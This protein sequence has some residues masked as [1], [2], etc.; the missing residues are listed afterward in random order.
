MPGKRDQPDGLGDWREVRRFSADPHAIGVKPGH[1]E[2]T[3]QARRTRR[4]N[5][6]VLWDGERAL[7]TEG[8]KR[9]IS[10]ITRPW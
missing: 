5:R 10:P 8:R 7:G 3:A 6:A 1:W 9:P 2:S 4:G